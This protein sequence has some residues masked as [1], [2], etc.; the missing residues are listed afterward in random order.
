MSVTISDVIGD[1]AF[2][3]DPSLNESVEIRAFVTFDGN[4]AVPIAFSCA[5]HAHGATDTATI[6][7]PVLGNPDW[8]TVLFRS[9]D[10]ISPVVVDLQAGFFDGSTT[11]LT[12][13]FYGIAQ[14]WKVAF[15]LDQYVTTFECQSFASAFAEKIT[16]ASQN[17]TGAQFVAQ[18]AKE[19]GLTP[20]IQLRDGQVSGTLTKV[21]SHDMVVGIHNKPKWDILTACAEYDDVELWVDGDTLNYVAP[22]KVARTTAPIRFGRDLLG[23]DGEHSTQYAKGIKVVVRSYSPKTRLSTYSSVTTDADGSSTASSSTAVV[24]SNPVFGTGQS[25]S[26]TTRQ[27][28]SGKTTIGSSNSVT[29][30]GLKKG[31]TGQLRDSSSTRNEY[32]FPNLTTE[33]CAN[34]ARAIWRRLS[35]HE[36][37]AD[38]GFAVTPETLPLI[39]VTTLFSITN[40]P[41]GSLSQAY[42]PREMAESFEMAQDGADAGGWTVQVTGVNHKISQGVDL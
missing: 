26:V 40:L 28:S 36:Y 13:R 18:V 19:A 27:N 3:L 42:Y 20:N 10:D 41:W 11:T 30:G 23:F 12:R 9:D 8:S 31:T 1:D 25:N 17:Q 6:T 29:S 38:F 7:V 4:P 39:A 35:R 37:I 24:V 33:E 21:Y 2:Q 22:A 32:V 34:R 14:S 16:T 5:F 15:H